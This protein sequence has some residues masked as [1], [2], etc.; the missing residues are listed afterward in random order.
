M[1][2]FSQS[3]Y[4]VFIY[5]FAFFLGGGYLYWYSSKILIGVKNCIKLL[6]YIIVFYKYLIIQF[7]NYGYAILVN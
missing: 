4:S 5:L 7:N 6:I 2:Y 3:A 1:K